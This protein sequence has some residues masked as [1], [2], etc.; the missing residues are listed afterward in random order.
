MQ[1]YDLMAEEYHLLLYA[2]SLAD[3]APHCQDTPPP[4]WLIAEFR[5]AAFSDAGGQCKYCVIGA[6][7]YSFTQ[8]V[9]YF[10]GILIK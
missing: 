1:I 7:T 2:M 10:V 9:Q 3:Q 4:K 8:R 5:Q 6:R